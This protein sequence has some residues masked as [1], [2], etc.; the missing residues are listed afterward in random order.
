MQP[1]T[2]P[3]LSQWGPTDYIIVAGVVIGISMGIYYIFKAIRA[4]NKS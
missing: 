3:T 2:N 1:Y 4:I